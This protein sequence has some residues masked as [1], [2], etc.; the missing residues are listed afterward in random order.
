MIEEGNPDYFFQTVGVVSDTEMALEE[1]EEHP[2]I[3]QIMMRTNTIFHQ[4]EI[5]LAQ[6]FV[7]VDNVNDPVSKNIPIV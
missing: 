3:I 7:T 5:I 1:Q 2:E 4:D 6:A